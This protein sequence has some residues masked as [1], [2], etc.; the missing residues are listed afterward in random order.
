MVEAENAD[1][2]S[3]SGRLDYAAAKIRAMAYMI[4]SLGKEEALPLDR[5]QIFFGIGEMITELATEVKQVSVELEEADLKSN[6]HKSRLT[7]RSRA[8][9]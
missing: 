6:K 5:D 1:T 3:H 2:V 4:E 9:S 7:Y 8:S